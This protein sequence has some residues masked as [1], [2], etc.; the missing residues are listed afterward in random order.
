VLPPIGALEVCAVTRDDLKRLVALLDAKVRRGFTVDAKGTRKPFGWK[1]AISAWGV[2]RALFRDAR[3]A[4][5]VDLC[6]R[7]DNPADG[8][9]GPDTGATKAKTYLWPSEFLTLA[10]CERVPVRW[11]RLFAIAVY[12]YAR[13]G[14]QA[15]LDWTTDVDLDHGT[16]HIHRSGAER[17]EQGY[18]NCSCRC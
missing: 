5:R 16:I 4:K 7:D 10:S 13:T 17:R 14:E 11:R 15:A 9:S 8:I 12:T 3:G 2:V 1:T 6:V 18:E